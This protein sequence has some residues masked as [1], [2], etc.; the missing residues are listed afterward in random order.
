MSYFVKKIKPIQVY[1]QDMDSDEGGHGCEGFDKVHTLN[2]RVAFSHES[3]AVACEIAMAV[4]FVS[5]GPS[6]TH[7]QGVRCGANSSLRTEKY[8]I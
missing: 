4:E 1:A 8:I 6:S 3:A 7:D 2:L 5:E